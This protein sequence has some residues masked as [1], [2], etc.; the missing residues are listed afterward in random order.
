MKIYAIQDDKS[1]STQLDIKALKSELQELSKRY[2]LRLVSLG[3]ITT[4]DEGG[5]YLAIWSNEAEP[6]KN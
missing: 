4:I 2:N 5:M 6:A 3:A 1:N